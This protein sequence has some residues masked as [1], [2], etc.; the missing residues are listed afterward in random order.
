MA[1]Y[2]AFGL[3]PGDAE[4]P[5]RPEFRRRCQEYEAGQ[6]GDAR[7]V[8]EAIDDAPWAEMLVQA[9]TAFLDVLE[10]SPVLAELRSHLDALQNATARAIV[11][12]RIVAAG[13]RWLEANGDEG[14][15]AEWSL[16][17][18]LGELRERQSTSGV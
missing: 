10:T 4:L 9:E 3:E 11:A 15:M 1:L 12:E 6:Y 5:P 2:R 18:A 17:E 16:R 13:K 8:W 14:R 7:P